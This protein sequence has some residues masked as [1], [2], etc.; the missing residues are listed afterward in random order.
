MKD[1]KQGNPVVA[2]EPAENGPRGPE[3]EAWWCDM[4]RPIV[5]PG[6]PELRLF[7]DMLTWHYGNSRVERP[8]VRTVTYFPWLLSLRSTPNGAEY[9]MQYKSIH[10]PG[11]WIVFK[12]A[13]DGSRW[14]ADR[15]VHGRN[16][17]TTV[18]PPGSQFFVL[19]SRQGV[20]GDEKHVERD[21][22]ADEVAAT[23]KTL[24]AP[25]A[26]RAN[27]PKATEP[28]DV[29]SLCL[30]LLE[31]AQRRFEVS[32]A[33]AAWMLIEILKAELVPEQNGARLN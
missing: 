32:R 6:R 13:A 12:A 29:P 30:K 14:Q 31:I 1:E 11:C 15:F 33:D 20:A 22:P 25:A 5:V 10:D 8:F 16:A 24:C 28:P 17:G 4:P 26:D 27:A 19:L 2:V 3:G 18:A 21:W 7:P 9:E 23:R